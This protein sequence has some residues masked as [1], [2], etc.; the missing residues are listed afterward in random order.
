MKTNRCLRVKSQNGDLHHFDMPE[1][2][3]WDFTERIGTFFYDND[4]TLLAFVPNT[5]MFYV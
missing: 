4:G 3:T 5:M 1:H 2:F